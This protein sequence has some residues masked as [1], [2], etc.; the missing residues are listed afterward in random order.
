VAVRVELGGVLAEVPDVAFLVLAVPVGG[1]LAGATAQV[2][3]VVRD[4]AGDAVDRLG[5]VRENVAR[6]LAVRDAGVDVAG[7]R[8]EREPLVVDRALKLD[9]GGIAGVP[10]GSDAREWAA[11]AVAPSNAAQPVASV[12][13]RR[14]ASS[15]MSFRLKRRG[16]RVCPRR[17]TAT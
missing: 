3:P 17:I 15:W 12:Q 14:F 4:D 1:A 13:R 6:G 9:A 8:Q 2:E 5:L 11:N 7:A 16:V 10:S